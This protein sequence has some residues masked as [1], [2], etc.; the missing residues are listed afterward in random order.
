MPRSRPRRAFTLIELLVV[1]AIIAVLI[2]LLLPAVQKVRE[3]AARARCQN[4]LKQIGIALHNYES[5]AQT[6]P[7][8]GAYPVGA[9]AGDVYSVQA[10]LLPFLE[11]G[12]LYALIDLNVT[13]ATQLDVI[14]QRI[15]VYLCPSEVKDQ[16]RDQGGT[17]PKITY[18][19]NYAANFGTYFV[20][21]PVAGRG[22]DGAIPV[23]ALGKTSWT[24]PA[25]FRDGMSNTIGFAEVKAYQ[26]YARN[27]S[28]PAAVGAAFPASVD[29]VAAMAATGTYR[30]E[31]GH[32]EW[33]D[34]PSHQTGFSFVFPP[35]TKV[36]FTPSGATAPVDVDVLTQ[37][38]GSHASKPS[39]S[40]VTSRS[41]HTGGVVN[42][43][44]M[45][46]SVR[47]VAPSVNPATWRAYGTRDGGEVATLD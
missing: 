6:Y 21:D 34:S 37:V 26:P 8:G 35:N 5:V 23:S 3:A 19:L 39:Y 12:S 9:S 32:T 18:P 43:L 7:P 31:I 1:I 44:L 46:G 25:S 14:K 27:T 17:P 40:I 13:P 29:E 42:V 28:T 11:Q 30:G 10:R 33:T 4:N 36:L 45:D 47:T 38:E 22:G 2:G 41:Y 16:P 24:K 15:A 20:W